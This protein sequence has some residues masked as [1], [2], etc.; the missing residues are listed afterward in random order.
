MSGLPAY[1][2]SLANAVVDGHPV[3]L[4]RDAAGRVTDATSLLGIPDTDTALADP[5]LLAA[6]QAALPDASELGPAKLGW[7]PTVLRPEKILMVGLNYRR[8]AEE[9]KNPIPTSPVLFGK[10]NNA[11]AAHGSEVPLPVSHAT[12][13]DYEAELVLVLG[14]MARD[15]PEDRALEHVFGYAVGNDLSARELQRR[16]SQMLLGKSL[17][18]FAPVGPW[19]IGRGLVADPDALGIRCRVNGALVQE[20]STADMIFG[21]AH[22]VSYAS[23]T[24]TLK[25]G[26]MVFTG[27]PEGVIAGKPEAERRWLRDGDQ[28]RTEIDGLGELEVILRART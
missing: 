10:F 6:L 27:T 21:C 18:G 24:M 12:W 23:R 28:I 2:F 11:L 25:P 15:V 3:L 5:G 14:A 20:S 7:M 9:T 4:A 19:I 26:D 17:D 8:H 13:F 22:L 16:T 1:S